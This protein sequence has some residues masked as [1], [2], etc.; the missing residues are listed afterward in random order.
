MD[1]V[2]HPLFDMFVDVEHRFIAKTWSWLIRFKYEK[3]LTKM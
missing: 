2:V 3:N 1:F